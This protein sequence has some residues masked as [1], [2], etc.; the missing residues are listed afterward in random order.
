MIHIGTSGWVYKHWVGRFYPQGLPMREWLGF[1][2]ER[3]ST[4][5]INRSF[6][7]QPTK[8]QFAAWY[9]QTN[10]RPDFVFAVKAS[11][12]ITHLKKLRDVGEAE[13]T[14]IDTA[15]ALRERLGPFLYQLPPYWHAN[16][17][18]LRRFVSLLPRQYLSAFEFR[19]LSW[20]SPEIA[21][22]LEEASCAQVIAI[23]GPHPT[24]TDAEPV[25]PFRYLRFHHG[26][27]GWGFTDNELR[28]W[29]DK[30]AQDAAS[31]R[32]AYVYFNNDPEG[33]A[34]DDATRLRDMLRATGIENVK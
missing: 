24:P 7:R 19:D 27:S 2:A 26:Q 22:I 6:Y 15:Q 21:R 18:R 14:L 12:Y 3:F 23:G 16:P 28:P 4:V 10:D 31:E 25:G 32:D 11:R 8:E 13:A 33:H 29:T 34:I 5:E 1:F 17:A 9:E 20:Y 30:L